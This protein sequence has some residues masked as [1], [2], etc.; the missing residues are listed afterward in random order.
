MTFRGLTT[1][2]GILVRTTAFKLSFA[3]LV[4]F[5]AFAFFALGYVAWNARRV[6]DDQILQTIDAEITGIPGLSHRYKFHNISYA[7]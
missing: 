1:S 4:V 7:T 2:L 3:Y 5:A 6:L